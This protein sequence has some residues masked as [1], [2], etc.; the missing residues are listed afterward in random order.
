M[1]RVVLEVDA[2]TATGGTSGDVFVG[3]VRTTS[4]ISVGISVM[5]SGG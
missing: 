1:Q 5:L 4:V 3:D 2:G